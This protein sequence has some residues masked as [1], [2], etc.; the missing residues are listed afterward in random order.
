ME[1]LF[2][3]NSLE[4][5]A[6]YIPMLI[7]TSLAYATYIIPWITRCFQERNAV[8]PRDYFM[9]TRG[10]YQA[11]T[12]PMSTRSVGTSHDNLNWTSSLPVHP[13]D[14]THIDYLGRQHQIRRPDLLENG[15]SIALESSPH[16]PILNASR[17]VI[18]DR[19]MEEFWVVF[20]REWDSG[21]RGCAGTPSSSSGVSGSTGNIDSTRNPRSSLGPQKRKRDDGKTPDEDQDRTPRRPKER[22]G[23]CSGTRSNNK[24]A[25]PFHKHNPQVY[26]IYDHH[27][28][29]LRHW[30]T[31]A[32]VK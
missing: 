16:Q 31:I 20:N 30:Q 4:D 9:V 19:V 3:R 2:S 32:R 1:L 25:C 7:S 27:V 14:V 22:A 12:D 18:V 8:T 11:S 15:S 5:F 28:C 13:L 23:L 26:S 17:N 10:S 6:P 24:F 29:A 21:F